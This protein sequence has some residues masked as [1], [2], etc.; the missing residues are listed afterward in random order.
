MK[1]TIIALG[2]VAVM[3]LGVTYAFAQ[4][5]GYGPGHRMM[6]GQEQWGSGKGSSL[7]PEQNTKFQEL[8]RK[9]IEE[10]AQLRG[11]ILTKRLELRSLWTDPKAD[12]KIMIDKEK[13]LRDLQNQMREKA[14]RNRLEACKLLT[15]EQIENWKPGWGM[16]RGFRGSHGMGRGMG[17]G[18][19]MG[20]GDGMCY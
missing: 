15:P 8:R 5:P 14:F 17:P 3:V 13:E 20:P 16:D 12:A 19:G 9:F 7:T 2:L 10:T 4:G 11:A 1:K 18:Y 6:H